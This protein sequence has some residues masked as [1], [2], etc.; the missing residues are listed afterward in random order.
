MTGIELLARS[1]GIHV[2]TIPLV[3][4][5]FLPS[6]PVAHPFRRFKLFVDARLARR[7]SRHVRQNGHSSSCMPLTTS[8]EPYHSSCLD[9]NHEANMNGHVHNIHVHVK[10][11]CGNPCQ[12]YTCP[13]SWS[14]P[15]WRQ[16]PLMATKD[17]NLRW[18]GHTTA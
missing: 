5:R 12:N 10:M 13:D 8:L 15:P 14:I 18:K 6:Q 9:G 11:E 2:H 17:G 3:V 16:S 7:C 4:S 1:T